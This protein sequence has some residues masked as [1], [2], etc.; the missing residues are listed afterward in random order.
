MKQSI[1]RTTLLLIC[2][3]LPLAVN[4]SQV[5]ETRTEH[6]DGSVLNRI[7]S[8]SESLH[9]SISWSGGVKIGDLYLEVSPDEGTDR[10]T[11]K[12]RVTDYGLFKLFYPV[13]DTFNSYVQ[14]P[15]KLPYRYEVHQKEGRG[16]ETRRLTL[17]DQEQREVTYIK[18]QEP[19]QKF[20]VIGRVYNEF[21]SFYI[22]R[23]L[24][25]DPSKEMI[26]PTFVDKKRHE[27][28]VR[29]LGQEK[30]ATRL[31]EHNTIK[32]QPKMNF[33][34]L[35]NKDGETVFWL[36][37]DTCRVPVEINSKILI[38]SLTAELVGYSNPACPQ[39]TLIAGN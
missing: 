16:S 8:G 2:T 37:D 24:H 20:T 1:V 21:S 23:A 7:F 19:P 6:I 13:D 18:N 5:R 25:L 3:L 38:G 27:V 31:G 39:Y 10:Y 30:K 36:T 34:G 12:V 14:G 28:A 11:I 15:L 29:V 33:K 32:V 4:A 26:I 9:Y 17:Y 22:N 35:Y